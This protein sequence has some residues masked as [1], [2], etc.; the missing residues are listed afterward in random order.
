MATLNDVI[1]YSKFYSGK[2]EPPQFPHEHN[3]DWSDKK[4]PKRGKAE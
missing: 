2:D 3:W 1:D 4:N